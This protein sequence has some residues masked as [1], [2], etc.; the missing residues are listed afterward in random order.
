MSLVR[1]TEPADLGALLPL[2]EALA[3]D[4]GDTATLTAASLFRDVFTEPK[5]MHALVAEDKGKIMGY[6]ALIPL[7]RLQYGQRGMDL[8]HL[9]VIQER[10]SAGVGT[11]LLQAA[12]SY[13]KGLG[14][15]YL[16][17]GTLPANTRAQGYYLA[18][19]FHAS[20]PSAH[21]Y[22]CDLSGVEPTSAP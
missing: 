6:A 2:I 21:R 7:A 22:A 10:R 15:D 19:G 3:R 11:A 13:A 8:H 14:C 12:Q 17:V 1:R 4:H 9:Y 16:T 5:W 20:P 18:Q